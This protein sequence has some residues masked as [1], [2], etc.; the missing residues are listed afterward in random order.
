VCFHAQ[1]CAEKYLKALLVHLGA[2][3]PKTHDLRLDLIPSAIA[4]DLR[5]EQVIPLNRYVI[6]G[7]Y[8]GEWEPITMAEARRA[9][10]MAQGVRQAVLRRLP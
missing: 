8:P 4:P 3:F 10:E 5:R 1:Q 2:A 6:E 9:L 7:R